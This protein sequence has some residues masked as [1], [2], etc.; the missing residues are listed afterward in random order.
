[1][2]LFHRTRYDAALAILTKGFK[3]QEG[4]YTTQGLHRG[5]WFADRPLDINEGAEGGVVLAVEVPEERMMPFEWIEEGKPYREFLAPAAVVNRFGLP[6]IC[7]VR[8]E[9]K[10]GDLPP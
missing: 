8:Q 3:D 7:D 9:S 4:Y 5:V 1:M 2:R 10:L 6:T